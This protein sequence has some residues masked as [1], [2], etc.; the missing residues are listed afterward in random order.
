VVCFWVAKGQPIERG[1]RVVFEGLFWTARGQ[2]GNGASGR[3]C[4]VYWLQEGSLVVVQ[5]GAN[6]VVYRL[7]KGSPVLAQAGAKNRGF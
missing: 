5:E 1:N 4:V 7:Q 3:C 2:S 6:H